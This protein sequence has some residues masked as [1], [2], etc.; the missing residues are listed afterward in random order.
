MSNVLRA[1]KHSFRQRFEKYPRFHQAGYRLKTKAADGLHL[2]ADF[3]QLR[4]VIA[5]KIQ[6]LYTRPVLAASMIMMRRLQGFPDRAPDLMLLRQIG[7]IGNCLTRSI[8]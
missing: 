8:G 1:E 5:I 4:N 2:P 3:R 7:C 6:A